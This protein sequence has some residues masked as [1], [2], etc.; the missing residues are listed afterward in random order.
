VYEQDFK[1]TSERVNQMKHMK[2]ILAIIG[3]VILVGLY[4]ATLISA[5]FTSPASTGL[6]RASVFCTVAVPVM[7]YAYMLVYKLLKNKNDSMNQ[8]DEK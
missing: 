2:R 5:I 3:I 1:Y 8:T 7:L 6:F 4:I